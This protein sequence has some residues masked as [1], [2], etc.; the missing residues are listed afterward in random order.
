MK[1]SNAF[2]INKSIVYL[3]LSHNRLKGKIAFLIEGL[4]KC[5]GLINLN[6]SNNKINES[7]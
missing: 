5:S 3:N 1:L 7:N 6:L 2:A 4:S